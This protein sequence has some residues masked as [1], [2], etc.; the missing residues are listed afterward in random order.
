MFAGA[1]GCLKGPLARGAEVPRNRGHCPGAH[2]RAA[3][4]RCFA[5]SPSRCLDVFLLCFTS[6]KYSGSAGLSKDTLGQVVLT[7]WCALTVTLNSVGMV[8]YLS[9]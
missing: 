9:L 4:G 3:Q 1:Q 7:E 6:A 2:A 8:K 5:A